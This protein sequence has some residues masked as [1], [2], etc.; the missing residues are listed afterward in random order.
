MSGMGSRRRDPV[1]WKTR[2]DWC[3]EARSLCARLNAAGAEP[4][5]TEK[6]LRE[7]ANAKFGVLI[8]LDGLSF[9]ELRALRDDLRRQLASPGVGPSA[10]GASPGR[11]ASSSGEA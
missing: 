11:G 8:G 6:S 10:Q 9:D 1:E 7:Y 2:A 5:W 4:P 3:E